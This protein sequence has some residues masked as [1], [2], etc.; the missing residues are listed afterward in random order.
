MCNDGISSVE[1]FLARLWEHRTQIR[2]EVGGAEILRQQWN[3][4]MFL[5]NIISSTFTHTLEHTDFS[6]C[7]E[8]ICFIFLINLLEENYIQC[9][10][11]EGKSILL[12]LF[13]FSLIFDETKSSVYNQMSPIE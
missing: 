13:P 4:L 7:C 6:Q 3:V 10:I 8:G 1:T 12:L 9:T 11:F 2:S 5:L